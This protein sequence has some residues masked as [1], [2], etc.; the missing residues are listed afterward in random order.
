M[1]GGADKYMAS[2]RAC[3]MKSLNKEQKENKK[4]ENCDKEN[5]QMKRTPK[6]KRN[7][8][9]AIDNIDQTACKKIKLLAN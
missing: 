4:L 2:C 8:L 1:I 5:K 3:H 7:P 9:E 6:K